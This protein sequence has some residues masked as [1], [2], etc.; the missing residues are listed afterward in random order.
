MSLSKQECRAVALA[1]RNAMDQRDRQDASRRITGRVLTH[2]GWDAARCVMVYAGMRGEVDTAELIGRG[3]A[4]GKIIAL[5]Y[6]DWNTKELQPV[7]LYDPTRLEPGRFG[8]PEPRADER[9][10]LDP[11]ELELVCVP[12]VAFDAACNRLG[13]GMGFYDR[14]LSSLPPTIPTWGLA[15]ESQVLDELP[16]DEHDRRLGAVV[17]EAR[18]IQR[19]AERE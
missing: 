12:G 5:P 9:E 15:Y 18:W 10:F 3:L 2:A 13:Y 6:T 4:A 14:F 11:A 16:H 19:E 1:R 7:R 8:V 17:T